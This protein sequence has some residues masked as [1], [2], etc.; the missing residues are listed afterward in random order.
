MSFAT[1]D[2][3]NTVFSIALEKR[4]VYWTDLELSSIY[5]SSKESVPYRDGDNI[6]PIYSGFSGNVTDIVAISP[7]KQAIGVCLHHCVY[8]FTGL[9]CT[10]KP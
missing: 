4:V 8:S 1:F 9:A 5:A 2:R 10:V 7:M 6:V 3:I